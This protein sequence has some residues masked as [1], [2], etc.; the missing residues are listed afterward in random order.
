MSNL[1]IKL[2]K[3]LNEAIDEIGSPECRQNPDMFDP[4]LYPDYGTRRF[5]EIAAK[6]VCN[7]CPAQRAC[8]AYALAAGEVSN[9]WG[10]LTPSER[11]ELM[12]KA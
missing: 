1:R 10:G 5:T 7:R 11:E 12:R 3:E 9:I 6:E 4:E 8:A 2:W